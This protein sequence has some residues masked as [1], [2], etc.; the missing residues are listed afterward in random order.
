VIERSA[1]VSD[2]VA[3]L[4]AA[5]GRVRAVGRLNLAELRAVRD[6]LGAKWIADRALV[7]I[8]DALL[9]VSSPRP[10]LVSSL[11][12]F[13]PIAPPSYPPPPGQPF[14]GAPRSLRPARADCR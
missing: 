2:D 10:G 13:D 1:R 9:W 12:Q 4:V 6:H 14:P 8:L 11:A 7:R 3:T 5:M